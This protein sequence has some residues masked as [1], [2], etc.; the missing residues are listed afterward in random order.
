MTVQYCTLQKLA[1]IRHAS[2]RQQA[3]R[4]RNGFSDITRL[5]VGFIQ[6]IEQGLDFPLR[7]IEGGISILCV[8]QPPAR[9]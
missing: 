6:L 1:A 8:L 4:L 3:V 7:V 2:H 9:R 5:R